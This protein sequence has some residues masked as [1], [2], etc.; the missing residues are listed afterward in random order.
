M[1]TP[2]FGPRP[3]R[4]RPDPARNGTP[5]PENRPF[6]APPAP[7]N[8]SVTA[9]GGGSEADDE[10]L[11]G[12]LDHLPGAGAAGAQEDRI[13]RP[14]G[15]GG[16]AVLRKGGVGCA[17]P[18]ILPLVIGDPP[19]A[20]GGLPEAGTEAVAVLDDPGGVGGD[21]REDALGRRGGGLQSGVCGGEEEV[22]NNEALS[23]KRCDSL[24]SV[25]V[26]LK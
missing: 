9:G 17:G 5:R 4:N 21:A 26:S 8:P 10:L 12:G 7:V 24:P 3:L 16:A 6:R 22:V 19:G 25:K 13:A 2:V 20:G 14:Q 18:A 23:C 11:A 1:D 15:E